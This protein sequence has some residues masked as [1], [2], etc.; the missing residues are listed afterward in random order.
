MQKA[1]RKQI[2]KDTFRYIWAAIG[3]NVLQVSIEGLMS[4][5]YANI[6]GNF[7]DAVFALDF[8]QGIKNIYVFLIALLVTVVL[9]PAI[10]FVNDVIL[11]KEAFAHDR[12]VLG[13]F[14]DKS[15]EAVSK[16]E[17][18]DML[19]R[20]DEDPNELR[21][22]LIFIISSACMIPVTTMYLIMNVWQISMLYFILVAAISTVK[23]F[24]PTLV[25][26]AE[27]KYH[28]EEKVY[29]SAVRTYET[30]ISNRGHLINLFGI[31]E[32]F[33]KR[34]DGLYDTFYQSTKKK[35]I[36]LKVTADMIQSFTD[37]FCT[38]MVLIMGAYLVA[39]QK[40]SPGSVA[41]MIGYY[42]VLNTI[43][44]KIDYI[45]RKAPILDNL[46]ERLEYFYADQEIETGEI[47]KSFESMQGEKL[48]FSYG[49]GA[50]LNAVSFSIESGEKV[51]VYGENG[52]GKST[53]LKVILGLL[54]GYQGRFKVNGSELSSIQIDSYRSLTAYAMQDP[55]L[56]KGTVIENIQVAN[57]NAEKAEIKRLLQEY[58]ILGIA[59]REIESG[60]YELSGGERQKLSIIRAMIKDASIIVIDEPEN[61]LDVA[62]MKKLEKWIQNS[63]KT[64][65]YVSHS[66]ELIACA[67]KRI[68]L[69]K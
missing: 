39:L 25:K 56:F 64:I 5:K 27:K 69:S 20:L 22:E 43:I 44:K 24:V 9:I 61:N 6:F 23:F 50:A 65:I 15:C 26:K 1:M 31:G 30:D 34:L 38:I 41:A 10:A 8:T 33:I 68:D 29:G 35:S 46:S 14:L 48:T 11:V 13:R 36:G 60:G 58:G 37:T 21:L 53:M 16:I 32:S 40:I 66:P 7:A 55:Y 52:S 18:G 12:K 3:L 4:V 67:D 57:F 17:V 63:Q 51:V 19:N 54:K 59:E 45:M 47:L 49:N 42:S 2:Y 62:T 28:N